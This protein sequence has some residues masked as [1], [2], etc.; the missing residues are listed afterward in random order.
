MGWLLNDMME[1]TVT[2]K[3]Q[4]KLE[5]TATIIQRELSLWFKERKYDLYVFSKSFVITENYRESI[6]VAEAGGLTD[7]QTP[8]SIRMVE[9]YLGSV[10]NQF[11]YYS[12]IILCNSDGEIVAASQSGLQ[13]EEFKLPKNFR[14]QLEID[15]YFHSAV[16]FS[17]DHRA[18]MMLIG[19][20]LL[21]EKHDNYDGLL[22]IEV[23]LIKIREILDSALEG[24]AWE[25]QPVATLLQLG[26]HKPFLTSEQTTV[27]D[28]A[29]IL[30]NF[31]HPHSE[32]QEYFNSSG[33][34][35]IGMLAPMKE[36][37]WAILVSENYAE[38]YDQVLASRN[39]NLIIICLLGIAV[40]LLAW[41]LARQ[42]IRPLHSITDAAR[43]V[44]DGDLNVHL[45][46]SNNDEL[47][48]AT[49]VFN[50]MVGE[51]RENQEALMKLATTDSLTNLA[52][53]KKI[54]ASLL[55]QFELF[56]RYQTKF[57]ILMMDIDHFKEVNDTYGHQT[58]DL[59]LAGI[60]EI[61]RNNVRNIDA[62]GRYGGEEFLI[63]LPESEKD[64]AMQTAQRIGEKISAVLFQSDKKVVR[65]TA[66]IG[67]ATISSTDMSEGDLVKRADTALYKAKEG[68]R[69]KCIYLHSDQES[70]EEN[71]ESSTE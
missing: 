63:I 29:E 64:E 50:D 42:I 17:E 41:V 24:N 65:V 9:T 12:N 67:V 56:T 59:V 23:N 15:N 6:R 70:Y 44:A 21:N 20:L 5:H 61:L 71:L 49:H 43:Q 33:E 37:Q 13:L 68:G 38:V 45:E 30:V 32:L 3:C 10:Q 52:N 53:R 8:A 25:S 39:R 66:S 69:N 62:A 51:L 19:T 27:P 22:A 57:S 55:S 40:G 4:Q 60:G 1:S 7:G 34:K 16:Y 58:G 18:P 11:E 35:T 48:L 2:E 14:E 54:M 31:D 26:N 28:E 36:F 47:G 46:R